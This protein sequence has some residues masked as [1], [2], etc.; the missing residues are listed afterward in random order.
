M[1]CRLFYVFSEALII[2]LSA[3]LGTFA[4]NHGSDI[5]NSMDWWGSFTTDIT[6]HWPAYLVIFL[7]FIVL[8]VILYFRDRREHDTVPKAR[9][10]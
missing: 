6:D 3:M 5:F 2:F 7:L 8:G 1:C 4:W 10:K 9:G